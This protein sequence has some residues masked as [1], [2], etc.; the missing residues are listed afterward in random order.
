MFYPIIAK[1][2][3]YDLDNKLRTI[4]HPLYAPSLADA[5]K[6]IEEHYGQDL[7]RVAVQCVD[8]ENTLFEISPELAEHYVKE[9]V[10]LD[11]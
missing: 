2:T 11:T 3:Y 6:R 8:C 9:G 10:I 4:N 7:E 1:V 5:V